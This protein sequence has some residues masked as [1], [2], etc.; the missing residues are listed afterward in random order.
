MKKL[1]N[2]PAS[3]LED[4]LLGLSA[5]H[6]DRIVY[7]KA[8]RFIARRQK[9]DG[10]RTA[11][12]SGGGSGHE[13]MH[14]GLVGRGMLDAACAGQIF[15]SPTP[16][17]MLAA[18]GAVDCG[19]GILFIVKNYAG[20][21]MNFEMAAELYGGRVETVVTDDDV[22]LIGLERRCRHWHR[23]KNRWRRRR[24]RPRSAGLRGAR[25]AHQCRHRL[26]GCG[27]VELH[28][29]CRRNADFHSGSR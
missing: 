21:I 26:H 17:Q 5:A 3:A 12:I 28:C 2:D 23:R 16:D 18:A 15:T 4:S 9:K 20:D 14:A 27:P 13:P 6:C 24:T 22:A 10:G 7:E 11:L 19:G 1:I 8:G 29:A 25:P